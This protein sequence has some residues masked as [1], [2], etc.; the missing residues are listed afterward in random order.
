M[1]LSDN[2]KYYRLRKG[3]TQKRLAAEIGTNNTTLSN[4]EK[5]ISKPDI[6]III[7]LSNYFGISI[8]EL[9]FSKHQHDGEKNAYPDAYLAE[10]NGKANGKDDGKVSGKNITESITENEILQKNGS[11]NG[12]PEGEKNTY[13]NTHLNE[14]NVQADEKVSSENSQIHLIPFYDAIAVAGRR[15]V[16]NMEAVTVPAEMINPGDWYMDAT[17]AMRVYDESM[18][19]EYRPGSV[20]A[21]KEVYDK[22]L[23]IPGEDYVIETPEYR[24]IKR[25]QKAE[26]KTCWLAC[27][28]NQEIWEQGPHK[29]K[30]IHEPFEIP[31]D[32]VRRV[33]L[34]LGEI[35]RKQCGNIFYT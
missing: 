9:I 2:L 12:N 16:A 11:L 28:V 8:D 5:G 7:K 20:V 1:E 18:I 19:P 13:L 15:S 25:L 34:V 24:V 35:R 30:L 17:C 10:K 21:L 26:D 4:W 32:L 27:S 23:I 14:I 29:G 31:I 3:V 22:R 33:F 6:D